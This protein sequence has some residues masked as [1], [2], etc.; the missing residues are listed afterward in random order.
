MSKI[1]IS[2]T[3]LQNIY[4]NSEERGN[5]TTGDYTLHNID[6]YNEIIITITTG[7]DTVLQA[8]YQTGCSF[9]HNSINLPCEAL[10][11]SSEGGTSKALCLV[12]D[13]YESDFDDIEEITKHLE[14][15]QNACEVIDSVDKLRQLYDVLNDNLP[16]ISDFVNSNEKNKTA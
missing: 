12:N 10:E 11:L 5:S 16:N 1:K 9:Y 14:L 15:V 8:F 3:E 4:H 6:V 2:T 7:S 13:I